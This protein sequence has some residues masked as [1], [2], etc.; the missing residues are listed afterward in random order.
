M[1]LQVL[2]QTATLYANRKKEYQNLAMSRVAGSSATSVGSIGFGIFKLQKLGLIYGKLIGLLLEVVY[3]YTKIWKRIQWNPSSWRAV[4][5]KYRNFPKYSTFEA[6][7]NMGHKQLPILVLTSFFSL[8]AAGLY[9]LANT[10]LTKPLGTIATSFAQVFYQKTAE[11]EHLEGDE[12]RLFF[13]K[14]LRVLFLLAIFPSLLVLFFG[15]FL[16]AFFLG[17]EWY[18]AGVYASWLIP[19]LFFNFLKTAFSSL[20]D[21]K[22]K[23][24]ENALWEF[25]F[26]GTGILAFYFAWRV[27][28]ALL[29]IKLYSMLGMLL[30]VGQLYW[31][32][33]LTKSNKQWD[34]QRKDI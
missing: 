9:A 33:Q 32:Y 13:L 34:I 14:N 16:F 15:P 6:L 2:L 22:N 31:Y 8:G 24:R 26:L 20:V 23:I 18:E 3:L 25:V 17:E 1:A 30:A 7:L 28:D 4:A 5:K 29:G 10:L 27:E 21:T 12:L 19:F 11:E